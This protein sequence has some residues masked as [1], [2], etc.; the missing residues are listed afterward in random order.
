MQLYWE[1]KGDGNTVTA[2]VVVVAVFAVL[3]ASMLMTAIVFLAK[4]LAQHRWGQQF[5]LELDR[6][7]GQVPGDLCQALSREVIER[8]D[9]YYGEP[10]V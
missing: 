3:S 4:I 2:D 10:V 6:F 9:R 8:S 1:V 5:D 7:W